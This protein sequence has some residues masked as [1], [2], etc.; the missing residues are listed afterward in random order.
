MAETKPTA[1]ANLDTTS[2]ALYGPLVQR[3]TN[4]RPGIFSL[5]MQTFEDHEYVRLGFRRPEYRLTRPCHLC[6]IHLAR[7][8]ARPANSIATSKVSMNS[9]TLIGLVR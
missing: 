2:P 4:A 7:P 3:E 9:L 8:A 6:L 1:K 5:P